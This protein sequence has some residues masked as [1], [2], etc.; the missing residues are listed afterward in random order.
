[1]CPGSSLLF[2][3]WLRALGLGLVLAGGRVADGSCCAPRRRVAPTGLLSE[4]LGSSPTRGSLGTVLSPA[5]GSVM[6]VMGRNGCEHG[7][8][9]LGTC[10]NE[11][12]K[13]SQWKTKGE[14]TA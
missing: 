10:G 11:D 8:A 1:M 5:R 12:Q 13:A 2:C 14:K 4:Q 6:V 3:C 9:G 7:G